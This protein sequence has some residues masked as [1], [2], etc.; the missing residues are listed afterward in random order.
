[1]TDDANEPDRVTELER[2]LADLEATSRQRIIQSELK[3]LAVRAGIV[4]LD[5]LKL[6]DSSALVLHDNGEVEGAEQ[7]LNALKRNK[8]WLFASGSSSSSASPPPS[9]RPAMKRAT[10][11]SRDEWQSARAELLRRR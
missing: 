4:D 1:M 2:R 9:A 6:A 7:L 10:Q 5:G 8:P 3:S 11:M